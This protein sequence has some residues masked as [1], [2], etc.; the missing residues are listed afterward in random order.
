MELFSGI[1][2]YIQRVVTTYSP[3]VVLAE[4]LLIG[5]A[6]WWVSRFLRGTRG[7]RLIKGFGLVFVT[8]Y[9]G[10]RLLPRLLGGESAG[11]ERAEFLYSR[12]LLVAFV[13]LIVAFQSELRRAL[14]QLGQT[15]VFRSQRTQAERLADTLAESASYLSR[16]KF[17]AIVAVER[18]VGLAGLMES[19]V[20]LDARPTAELL[21]TIFYPGSALHDMGVV[22][23]NGRVGAGGCQ[24]PLAESG[25]V[26]ASMGA[27]H[28]AALGLAQESDAV[29]VVV[30]EETGRVSL[31]CDGQL[32][33]GL[34]LTDLREMIFD[35]LAQGASSRRH[36]A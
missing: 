17:G 28:R 26:D 33:L 12:F 16:N 2:T 20:A 9:V 31:A 22:I 6:V 30:S 21:N 5:L 29:V 15:S 34:T 3:Y 27:R 8:V 23:T 18:A 25:D 7:A 10:I 35:L 19:G 11:W 36:T 1:T 24:F 13:A 14:I 4:L 32:Y